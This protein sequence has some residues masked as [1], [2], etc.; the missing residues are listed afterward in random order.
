MK[1]RLGVCMYVYFMLMCYGFYPV[2]VFD[3]GMLLRSVCLRDNTLF[4]QLLFCVRHL[5]E[6]RK[7]PLWCMTFPAILAVSLCIVTDC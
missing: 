7:V 3:C 4:V 1:D 6:V 5:A 2:H